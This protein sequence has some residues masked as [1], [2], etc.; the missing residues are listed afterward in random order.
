MHRALET[1]SLVE[2]GVIMAS[3]TTDSKPRDTTSQPS[4]RLEYLMLF[5]IS[6][7]KSWALNLKAANTANISNVTWCQISASYVITPGLH[8]KATLHCNISVLPSCKCDA[9]QHPDTIRTI[10][11]LIFRLFS[12][13]VQFKQGI[14]SSM[15]HS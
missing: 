3:L 13:D 2:L 9:D 12:R 7:F 5:L 10:Q 1:P 11:H 14:P 15:A 6:R 4:E 8:V